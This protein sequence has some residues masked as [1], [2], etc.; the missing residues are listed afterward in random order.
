MNLKKAARNN[1]RTAQKVNTLFFLFN[2]I[3]I[4]TV[5]KKKQDKASKSIEV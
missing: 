3:I 4:I 1:T 2:E 5:P